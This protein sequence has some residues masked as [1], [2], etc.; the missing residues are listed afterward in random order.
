MIQRKLISSYSIPIKQA[1][2]LITDSHTTEP[3]GSFAYKILFP[4]DVDL[5]EQITE[6]CGKSEAVKKIAI[7]IKQIVRGLIRQ[8]GYFLAEFKAGLDHRYP[9]DRDL[10]VLR[11]N[12]QEILLGYKV[13]PGGIQKTLEQALEDQTIV[14]LDIWV[15]TNGR[16]IEMSNFFQ[17]HYIDEQGNDLLLNGIPPDYTASIKKDIKTY[18]SK[19]TLNAFKATKRMMLLAKAFGDDKS[20]EHILPLINSGAGLL[21]Q[22]VSDMNTISDMVTKLQNRAPYEFIWKEIDFF[23][24]RLS[25]IYEFKFDEAMV[26]N[27]INL[28][29]QSK[30][31]GDD[32]VNKLDE[33]TSYLLGI[34][35]DITLTYDKLHGL[36]PP[37]IQFT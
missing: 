20:L 6:C 37:P 29:V 30:A 3:V 8:P 32:L 7:D 33:V 34:L 21:Y 26:D 17:L 13:L 24:E 35:N 31:T 23:K 14:K 11:W 4:G 2:Y 5:R 19:D 36:Y 16:Y 27:K 25:Y 10:Y 15:P 22:V 1:I 9:N 12:E 28:I 18:F